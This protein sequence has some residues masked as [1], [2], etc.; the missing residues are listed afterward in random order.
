[1]RQVSPL[2]PERLTD[3][4][5]F[6]SFE[7]LFPVVQ[8]GKLVVMAKTQLALA[9]CAVLCVAFPAVILFNREGALFFV[10]PH[11]QFL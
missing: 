9:D 5:V 8:G 11:L 6:V 10:A 1:M 3:N 2:H 7:E 4:I